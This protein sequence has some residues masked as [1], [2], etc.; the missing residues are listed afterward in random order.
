MKIII[1][2]YKEQKEMKQKYLKPKIEEVEVAF[3][4]ALAAGSGDTSA[5]YDIGGEGS[6]W[7]ETGPIHDDTGGGPGV[8]GAKEG[9][10]MPGEE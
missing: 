10:F 4:K 1:S 8:S 3:E 5:G 2:I 7:P 9:G 6:K